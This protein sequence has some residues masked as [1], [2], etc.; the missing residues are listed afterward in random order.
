M[1]PPIYLDYHATTP[2]DPR[3]VE[4]MLPYFT[5]R[6]GN[7]SSRNHAFGWEA[8]KAVEAARR[9]V[10][11]LVGARPREVVFTSGATESNNLAIKGLVQATD[12]GASRR[13]LVT[14]CTEHHAVLDPCRRLAADE[15]VPLTVLPVG[16]DGLVDLDR[17]AGSVDERTLL[18]SVMAANNEIGVLQPLREIVALAHAHGALVHTDASQALGRVPL[19]L[20]ALG[21]DLASFT[22]HKMYGPKG[23][24][25]L[26]VSRGLGTAPMR[27]LDGGSHERGLRPGTLNVPGIVG[28]GCAAAL[29][30]EDAA[31]EA[32]RVG[33]FRDRLL[34]GLR[35]RLGGVT[36]NGSIE[37]RLP[38]NLNVSVHDV[39]GAS[40]HTA[41][42]DLAVSSGAACTTDSAEPSHVLAALG[43]PADLARATIRFGLGRFTTAAEIDRALERLVQVVSDLRARRAAIGATTRERSRVHA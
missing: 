11:A 26:F 29:C 42:D 14:V 35:A 23:V 21:V 36:V 38:H 41:L 34:D 30:R 7:A 2:V 22:A 31:A 16:P 24:G 17:L 12:R 1:Q 43:V 19:D 10:A 33:A 20:H 28:F 32:T 40:L 8:G 27:Q 39:D 9:E 18:V 15:G 25:A 13:G 4:A 3:V 5:E 6:F 37:S